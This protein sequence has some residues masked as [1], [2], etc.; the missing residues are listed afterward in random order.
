ML[1]AEWHGIQRRKIPKNF[2]NSAI[3]QYQKDL[4]PPA[5]VT[6]P[7]ASLLCRTYLNMKEP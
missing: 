6:S 5:S 2:L 4:G 7:K 3:L 1:I